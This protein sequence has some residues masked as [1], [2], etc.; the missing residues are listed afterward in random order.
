MSARLRAW[1]D[2]FSFVIVPPATV[3]EVGTR[4][5]EWGRVR[6]S[7]LLLFP[8]CEACST[9]LNREVH[10]LLPFSTHPQL[11]LDL[12]NLFTLCRPHHFV[13]G[14]D[15]DG[16]G[17]RGPAWKHINLNCVRDVRIYRLM[18]R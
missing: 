18:T 17:P 14:H 16:P 7:H 5:P 15:P 3:F 12:D 13:F 1:Y 10:H 8:V 4:H 9:P 11:E 2:T 6:A